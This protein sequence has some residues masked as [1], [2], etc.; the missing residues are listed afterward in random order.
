MD[1]T[2]HVVHPLTIVHA[3]RVLGQVEVEAAEEGVVR[4]RLVLMMGVEVMLRGR[5]LQ[6]RLQLQLCRG[7]PPCGPRGTRAP[8]HCQHAREHGGLWLSATGVRRR[9]LSERV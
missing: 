2:Y 8:R 4:R 9:R 7:A 6:L 3:G 5:D 1:E